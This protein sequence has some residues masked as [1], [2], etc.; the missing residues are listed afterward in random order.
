MDH[1]MHR[2]N[3][4]MLARQ[5][6]FG[7][8]ADAARP[9]RAHAHSGIRSL[10]LLLCLY[11]AHVSRA[12]THAPSSV[13][14]LLLTPNVCRCVRLM[15]RPMVALTATR[16]AEAHEEE[17]ASA[18]RGGPGGA[19]AQGDPAPD[20]RPR[21]R[22]HAAPGRAAGRLRRRLLKGASAHGAGSWGLC[23]SAQSRWATAEWMMDVS[24]FYCTLPAAQRPRFL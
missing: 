4:A 2:M 6:S 23:R 11:T 12:R 5:E 18:A 19:D 8:L 22:P 10:P 7:L 24:V 14:T 3:A 20:Q 16:C 17:A 1:M 21:P 13:P 9:L 15:L